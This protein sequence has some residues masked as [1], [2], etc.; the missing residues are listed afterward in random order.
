MS[1][2]ES[3]KLTALVDADTKFKPKTQPEVDAYFLDE[4]GNKRCTSCKQY[5]PFTS[6]HKWKDGRY[7]LALACKS[8]ANQ[9][10]RNNHAKRMAES[11]E[12]RL[13][14]K[15]S[16]VKSRF[17]LSLQE[18][19]ERLATQNN[20]CAICK[21]SKPKGGWA[22]DHDH[23][24]GSIRKFLCNICNRGLGYFNDNPEH[25]MQAANYLIEHSKEGNGQWT[26]RN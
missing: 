12:Y 16:Y 21:T 24:T 18:Y 1:S 20:Q 5:K 13:K 14:K 9:K 22:L 3:K 2:L 8:C 7:G 4:H 17:G 15:A 25:L 11:E 6:Y 26:L 23:K 19:N 10:S